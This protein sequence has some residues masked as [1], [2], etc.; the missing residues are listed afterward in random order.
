MPN[1]SRSIRIDSI[2]DGSKNNYVRNNVLVNVV[3]RRIC[4]E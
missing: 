4:T 2:I 3:L 1:V